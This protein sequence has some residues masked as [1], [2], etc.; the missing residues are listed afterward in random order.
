[1]KKYYTYCFDFPVRNRNGLGLKIE[2]KFGYK[3]LKS[4]DLLL[5]DD[6]WDCFKK[7]ISTEE[8]DLLYCREDN[9]GIHVIWLKDFDDEDEAKD[10][11]NKLLKK[12]K[13][14][15]SQLSS[16]NRR[17][18]MINLKLGKDTK[19]FL[20]EAKPLVIFCFG[21]LLVLAVL[22]LLGA[23]T[24]GWFL[25]KVFFFPAFL[26]GVFGGLA[27]IGWLAWIAGKKVQ[28]VVYRK[29]GIEEEDDD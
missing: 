20:E 17:G 10:E 11:L 4:K 24:G 27:G 19:E 16:E 3:E 21:Y 29:L 1:M 15:K 23:L 7:T 28:E 22:A 8:K 2:R 26:I 5:H 25:F 13:G 12:L 9:L 6:F 18:G 14:S